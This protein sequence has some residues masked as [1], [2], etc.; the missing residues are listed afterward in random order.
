MP[1][2]PTWYLCVLLICYICYW[3]ILWLAKR[4][5]VIP[6]YMFIAM[7]FLG[8]GII[9]YNIAFPY[10]NRSVARGYVA[11]F[12]GV[13]LVDLYKTVLEKH[14]KITCC[15]SLGVI[16]LFVILY[17]VDAGFFLTD[18][19]EFLLTFLFY[20]ALIALFVCSETVIKLFSHR[21]FRTFGAVSFEMY[22]WHFVIFMFI[23]TLDAYGVINFQSNYRTMLGVLL[24]III[25]GYIACYLVELPLTEWLIKRLK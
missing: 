3:L 1:N 10:L 23:S 11:F 14:R 25:W 2:H 18:G 22:L 17:V 20:P 24:I 13:V 19:Q 12:T 21:I 15:I 5:S 16:L 9:T 7:I 6:R 8:M 4:L